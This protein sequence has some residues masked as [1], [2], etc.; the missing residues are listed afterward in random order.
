MYMFICISACIYM[1]VYIYIHIHVYIHIY[2]LYLSSRENLVLCKL[3]QAN[4][5]P[6][7][8]AGFNELD[9]SIN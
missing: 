8:S 4:Q 2:M 9:S 3:S 6:H 5:N 1:Y 7:D